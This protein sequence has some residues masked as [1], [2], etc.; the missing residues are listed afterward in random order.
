MMPAWGM[1][2]Q[3]PGN[4]NWGAR[5]ELNKELYGFMQGAGLNPSFG[6]FSNGQF[7]DWKSQQSGAAQGMID[8][9]MDMYDPREGG[10]NNFGAQG[11]GQPAVNNGGAYGAQSR[12]LPGMGTSSAD[13]WSGLSSLS[14]LLGG[15]NSAPRGGLLGGGWTGGQPSGGSPYAPA[16]SGHNMLWSV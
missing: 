7:N 9:W 8:S 16:N 3:L 11:W 13:V 14:G 6:G 10:S 5:P 4:F 15:L 2:P 12:Q 1:G